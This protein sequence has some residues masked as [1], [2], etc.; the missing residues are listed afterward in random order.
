MMRSLL[1]ALELYD[2]HCYVRA[3]NEK[4]ELIPTWLL[5][6]LIGYPRYGSNAVSTDDTFSSGTQR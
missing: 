6:A 1:V 5:D 4:A 3:L 2:P